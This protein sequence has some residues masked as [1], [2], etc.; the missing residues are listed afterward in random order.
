MLCISVVVV[1][2]VVVVHLVIVTPF[3]G[4]GSEQRDDKMGSCR[5]QTP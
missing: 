2:V 1:V 3:T 4:T 5:T